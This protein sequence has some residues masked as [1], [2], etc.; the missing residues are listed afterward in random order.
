LCVQPQC[1]RLVRAILDDTTRRGGA[2]FLLD[3]RERQ[4]VR[5]G[6]AGAPPEDRDSEPPPLSDGMV[7]LIVAGLAVALVVGYLFVNKLVDM[8]QEEDCALAH[9]HNCGA[10]APAAR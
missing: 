9:R 4:P 3:A 2:A 10:A 6:N 5:D 8:S 1:S 7:A